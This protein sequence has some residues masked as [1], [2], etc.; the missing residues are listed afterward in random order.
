MRKL[1]ERNDALS[2]VVISNILLPALIDEKIIEGM[3]ETN[4]KI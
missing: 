1:V 2:E 4:G 3:K